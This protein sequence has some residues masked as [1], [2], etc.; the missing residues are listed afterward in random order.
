MSRGL[1]FDEVEGIW[2]EYIPASD[3][4]V[5]ENGTKLAKPVIQAGVFS[6]TTPAVSFGPY[7]VVFNT[8]FSTIPVVVA[9]SSLSSAANFTE[10]SFSS[11]TIN[12]TQFQFFIQAF[13]PGQIALAAGTTFLMSWIAIG[14]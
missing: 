4:T 3:P 2:T 8:A 7:T 13:S 11:G 10:L 1:V 6:I 9:W 12:T 5:I 14:S